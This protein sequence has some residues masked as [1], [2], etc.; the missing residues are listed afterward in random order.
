VTVRGAQNASAEERGTNML[1]C[2][3]DDIMMELSAVP[4]PLTEGLV[5]LCTIALA[6][7]ILDRKIN[8]C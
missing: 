6:Y 1:Q 2:S 4:L 8:L 7:V 5:H 3:V